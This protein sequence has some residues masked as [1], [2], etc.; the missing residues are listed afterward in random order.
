MTTSWFIIQNTEGALSPVR[1]ASRRW[2]PCNGVVGTRLTVGGIVT[3]LTALLLSG[4]AGELRRWGLQQ[5]GIN[6]REGDPLIGLL[7][8]GPGAIRKRTVWY[9]GVSDAASEAPTGPL[10]P[11]L[12]DPW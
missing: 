10:D 9:L 12:V 6:L 4:L 2:S 1:L 5:L 11:N 8:G 3:T 7:P